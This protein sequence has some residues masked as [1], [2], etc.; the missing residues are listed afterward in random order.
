M[1]ELEKYEL[2]NKADSIEELEAA[3]DTIWPDGIVVGRTRTFNKDRMKGFIRGVV[4]G[5]VV[6]VNVL[7]RKYGIRQQALYLREYYES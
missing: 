7:T 2:V 1:T 6:L 4:E 3:M 5:T